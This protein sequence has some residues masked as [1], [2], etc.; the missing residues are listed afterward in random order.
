MPELIETIDDGLAV[1]RRTLHY[2]FSI[3]EG[4]DLEYLDLI[5]LIHAYQKL[6][7]EIEDCT[8]QEK[9]IL[10]FTWY[11]K[12]IRNFKSHEKELI[13]DLI[14]NPCFVAS[15]LEVIRLFIRPLIKQINKMARE[16]YEGHFFEMPEFLHVINQPDDS[17]FKP[18]PSIDWKTKSYDFVTTRKAPFNLGKIDIDLTRHTAKKIFTWTKYFQNGTSLLMVRT[19]GDIFLFDRYGNG[20]TGDWEDPEDKGDNIDKIII[21]HF[22][23]GGGSTKAHV[24]LAD[25]V[26]RKLRQEYA[27]KRYRYHFSNL[28]WCGEIKSSFIDDFHSFFFF[29]IEYWTEAI[30]P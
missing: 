9:L 5:G 30:A 16:R 23:E 27:K 4:K 22:F 21:V 25:Y 28:Q 18:H 13:S 24:Y 2:Y 17:R 8:E 20:Y 12:N 11:I 15:A 1:T 6:F 7:P 14:N 29:N 3:V 19:K 10:E 26:D